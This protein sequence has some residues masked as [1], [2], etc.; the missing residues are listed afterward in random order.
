MEVTDLKTINLKNV[1][2]VEVVKKVL[3]KELLKS[4]GR[5]VIFDF[6][7]ETDELDGDNTP[8]PRGSMKASSVH[9]GRCF[10][11]G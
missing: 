8:V 4:H 7:T 3:K 2:L 5:Y 10:H 6:C 9:E 1:M 11:N